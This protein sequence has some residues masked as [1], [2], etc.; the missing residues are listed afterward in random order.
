MARLALA[1]ALYTAQRKGDLILFGR[2]HV[3]HG[4]LT[5][6]QQKNIKR[7]PVR[8]EIPVIPE[9]Q[10]VIDATPCGDLTFLVSP[11]G[12]PFSLDYFGKQFRMWCDEA[13]LPNCT[14]HGLR[15]AAAARLAELGR[16][17]T[18]HRSQSAISIAIRKLE[19]ELDLSLFSLAVK[20]ISM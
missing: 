9:L 11:N 12:N 18:L 5:F 8:M 4:W 20:F 2:Q 13:G 16:S 17:E 10:H 3:Q 15:K 1:L 19:E 6:T 7:K 14:V